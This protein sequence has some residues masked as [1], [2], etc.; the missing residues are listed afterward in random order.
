M[1]GIS[2]PS[3]RIRFQLTSLMDLLLI[4]VFAQYMEYASNKSVAQA[5]TEQAIVSASE[6]LNQEHQQRSAQLDE[7]RASMTAENEKL[8]KQKDEAILLA[9]ESVRRQAMTERFLQSLLQ[10]DPE[11]LDRDQSP[12]ESLQVLEEAQ[13]RGAAIRDADPTKLL[14]FLA[15]YDEL[16]KRAEVWTVHVSDRGNT[17]LQPGMG[18]VKSQSFRL[19]SNSQAQRTEEFVQQMRVAYSQIPEPKGLV[20]ILVSFSPRAIA[21]N[22]QP[23]IDGMP[24]VI[25]AFTKDTEGQ[26]RFEYTVI[27]AITDPQRDLPSQF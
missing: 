8:R 5:E 17:E 2:M 4:I 26:T 25:D 19:E 16:L 21:G 14:R 23:V 22:Y 12:A 20:V 24:Q 3:R 9:N 13:K 1:S 27:G 6:S 7:L 10:V 18:Q 11:I 15:G